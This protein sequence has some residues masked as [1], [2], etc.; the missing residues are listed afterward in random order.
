MLQ[1]N[2]TVE[3]ERRVQTQHKRPLSSKP[4][5]KGPPSSMNRH[6]F[7]GK[8]QGSEE[9]GP[10][11]QPQG[12]A[13]SSSR[14]KEDR[15]SLDSLDTIEVDIKNFVAK[16]PKFGEFYN[17]YKGSGIVELKKAKDQHK[18]TL[19]NLSKTGRPP[20]ETLRLRT[21]FFN[22]YEPLLQKREELKK[23]NQSKQGILNQQ[24]SL[25]PPRV[26]T[27]AAQAASRQNDSG[28]KRVVGVESK[29]P[30]PDWVN[31]PSKRGR[32]SLDLDRG[33]Q[34][35]QGGVTAPGYNR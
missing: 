27:T 33:W 26:F 18:V 29:E 22:G 1:R 25:P 7:Y 2:A 11:Q 15:N 24:H 6:D 14:Q 4:P 34:N 5:A 16:N 31:D 19:E 21:D 3:N 10:S 30:D 12:G 8:Q 17:T 9:V 23:I 28:G 32:K 13:A 35:S 20:N